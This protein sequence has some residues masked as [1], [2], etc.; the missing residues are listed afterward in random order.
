[1]R[2]MTDLEKMEA[3][4]REQRAYDRERD[5]RRERDAALLTATSIVS[6]SGQHGQE[7]IDRVFVVAARVLEFTRRAEKPQP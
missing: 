2:G 5:R 3:Q 6:M 1:M 4:E 7:A